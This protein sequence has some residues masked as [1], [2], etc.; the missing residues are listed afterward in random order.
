M[1]E[2]PKKNQ[3]F[4]YTIMPAIKLAC[5]IYTVFNKISQEQ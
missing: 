1:F 2:T 4:F 5:E 3:Y